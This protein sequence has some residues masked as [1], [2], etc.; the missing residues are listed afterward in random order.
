MSISA[1]TGLV[2]GPLS[3]LIGFLQ[4]FQ[5]TKIGLERSEEVHVC[6]NEDSPLQQEVPSDAPLNIIV[7]NL[8][9]PSIG[10][11]R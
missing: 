8:T 5:V 1:I 4:L 9:F 11:I 2:N 3:Q 6:D 10:S 7:N